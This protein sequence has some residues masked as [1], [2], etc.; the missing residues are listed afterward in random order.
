MID[1]KHVAARK[2]DAGAVSRAGAGE[3]QLLT[4]VRASAVTKAP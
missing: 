4:P 3:D 2:F 1:F